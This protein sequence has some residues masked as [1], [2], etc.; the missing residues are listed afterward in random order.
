M[1]ED[2]KENKLPGVTSEAPR[3]NNHGANYNCSANY[4]DCA[5]YNLSVSVRSVSP[6]TLPSEYFDQSELLP[7][8]ECNEIEVLYTLSLLQM[9]QWLR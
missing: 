7:A 1:A 9:P 2:S 5:N 8:F 6:W 3:M 4:S